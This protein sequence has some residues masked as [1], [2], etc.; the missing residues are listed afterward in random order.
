[1]DPKKF[2]FPM[3]EGHAWYEGEFGDLAYQGCI[4]WV[5]ILLDQ[6]KWQMG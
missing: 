1:M 2:G 3:G 6:V 5:Y 4:T